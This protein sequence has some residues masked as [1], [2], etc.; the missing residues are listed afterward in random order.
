VVAAVVVVVDGTFVVVMACDVVVVEGTVVATVD[1]VATS[2]VSDVPE[3]QPAANIPNAATST[4]TRLMSSPLVTST[5]LPVSIIELNRTPE[6][7]NRRYSE[8]SLW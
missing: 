4:V 5:L 3:E 6:P 8:P 1:V 7:P 2:V